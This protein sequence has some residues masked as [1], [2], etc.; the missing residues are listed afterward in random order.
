[1]TDRTATQPTTIE[2]EQELRE[3]L[4]TAL[5]AALSS[6]PISASALPERMQF[7]V[8]FERVEH[9]E[10]TIEEFLDEIWSEHE[11]AL[12]YLADR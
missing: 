8:T 2:T 12:R 10:S 5:D 4:T 6:H 9:S 3:L 7:E 1:M 11:A